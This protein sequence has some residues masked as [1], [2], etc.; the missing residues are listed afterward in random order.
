MVLII[1]FSL[2]LI[3]TPFTSAHSVNIKTGEDA[4]DFTLSSIDGDL[5]TLSEY[6]GKIKVL[7]YW[8]PNQKRSHLALKEGK[9]FSDTFIWP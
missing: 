3:F 9:L 2:L 1:I 7:I 8:R 6:E 4:P 5:V